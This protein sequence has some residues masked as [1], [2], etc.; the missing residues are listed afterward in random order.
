MSEPSVETIL[1]AK[2]VAR[3]NGYS[4]ELPDNKLDI[5][6]N[7]AQAAGYNV[8]KAS[9]L[10]VAKQTAK[11]AGYNVRKM[12]ELEQ[13]KQVAQ[14]AGYTVKKADSAPAPTP[15][16]VKQQEDKNY[17]WIEQVAASLM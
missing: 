2:K 3:Q 15:E 1:A 11:D 6:K 4:V 5:A 7:I 10:D 17:S 13:A 14:D 16:E 9:S 8:R 12:S